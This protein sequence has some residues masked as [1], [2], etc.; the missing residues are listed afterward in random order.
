MKLLMPEKSLIIENHEI[1]S[2]LGN[3]QEEKAVAA[4]KR[5]VIGRMDGDDDENEHRA[6]HQ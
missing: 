6:R 1:I 3:S 5:M 2:R 4:Q